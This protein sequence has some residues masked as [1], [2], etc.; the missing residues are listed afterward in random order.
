MI[1]FLYGM[2]G[3]G[4][5]VGFGEDAGTNTGETCAGVDGEGRQRPG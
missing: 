2:T 1:R 5:V 3:A 4:N